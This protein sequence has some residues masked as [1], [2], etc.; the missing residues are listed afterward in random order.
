MAKSSLKV[1]EENLEYANRNLDFFLKQNLTRKRY[2]SVVSLMHE[3]VYFAKD[4]GAEEEI[5][6]QREMLKHPTKFD[7]FEH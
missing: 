4:L 2:A 3:V 1:C 7:F 5:C 6:R